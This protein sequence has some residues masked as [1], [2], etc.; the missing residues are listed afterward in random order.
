MATPLE[1]IQEIYG[2]GQ[3]YSREDMLRIMSAEIGSKFSPDIS[4]YSAIAGTFATYYSAKKLASQAIAKD[5][6]IKEWKTKSKESPWRNSGNI[7]LS[8]G[9][10][11]DFS[12]LAKAAK[13]ILYNV[14]G[15]KYAYG[16][17]GKDIVQ[18]LRI[19]G[20]EGTQIEV[21]EKFIL[22]HNDAPCVDIPKCKPPKPK[23][24]DS[25]SFYESREWRELRYRV[26]TKYG[27][28]CMGCGRTR[29]DGVILHVDHI[30]PRSKYPEL[31]LDENNL[32]VLCA[33]CN[34]G[35][36]NKFDTDHR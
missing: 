24:Q 20:Y 21:L 19:K 13:G 28:K 29:K 27:W 2:K 36:S 12:R 22:R 3:K 18:M 14:F 5:I 10:K 7:K 4:R 16:A 30:K 9:S 17:S 23:K 15:D 34:I 31:E 32:Q 11:R 35:K 6:E 25:T 26:L 1:I 33:D 8:R